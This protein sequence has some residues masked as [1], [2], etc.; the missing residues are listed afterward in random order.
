M[1]RTV[2]YQKGL[3]T[4]SVALVDRGISAVHVTLSSEDTA[5]SPEN[6]RSF[7]LGNRKLVFHEPDQTKVRKIIATSIRTKT[8]PSVNKTTDLVAKLV[9]ADPRQVMLLPSFKNLHRTEEVFYPIV[10]NAEKKQGAYA[11]PWISGDCGE[12]IA[13][14]TTFKKFVTAG[15]LFG[16]SLQGMDKKGMTFPL[17]K[18]DLELYDKQVISGITLTDSSLYEELQFEQLEVVASLINQASRPGEPKKLDYHLPYYD[19]ILYGIKLFLNQKI[20]DRALGLF[21]EAIAE[22]KTD[23]V[24]EIQKICGQYSIEVNIVCP[25]D[26]I[27]TRVDDSKKVFV[28]SIFQAFPFLGEG[29]NNLPTEQEFVAFVLD[30]LQNHNNSIVFADI[31]KTEKGGG[32]NE[33]EDLFNIANPA[34]IAAAAKGMKDSEVCSILPTSKK[35]IQVGYSNMSKSADGQRQVLPTVFNVTLLDMFPVYTESNEESGLPFYASDPDL[36]TCLP[37]IRGQL[38]KAQE[39]VAELGKLTPMAVLERTAIQETRKT[40]LML[41]DTKRDSG[42]TSATV[43]YSVESDMRPASCNL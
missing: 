18:H 8:M 9:G 22:R 33:I 3:K 12:K 30:K 25:F 16:A 2:V 39:K 14:K 41:R 21:F 24:A 19:Y 20:T 10:V 36:R 40:L 13:N 26:G 1:P 7:S 17:I 34:I 32:L 37:Q 4:V 31:W 15:C 35:Q 6:D 11:Y 23:H 42:S 38:I 43:D 27:F 28:D 5:A 29:S